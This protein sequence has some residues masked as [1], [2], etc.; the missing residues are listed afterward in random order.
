ME[1]C[2]LLR[3]CLLIGHIY[4]LLWSFHGISKGLSFRYT[5]I[6]IKIIQSEGLHICLWCLWGGN[7]QIS[8]IP[9]LR[10]MI[11]CNKCLCFMLNS[12][13]DSFSHSS[14]ECM[15]RCIVLECAHL[16]CS[17]LK[18]MKLEKQKDARKWAEWSF[19][20][21]SFS[22]SLYSLTCSSPPYSHGHKQPV[23]SGFRFACRWSHHR[24]L[25]VPPLNLSLVFSRSLSLFPSL[26][27]AGRVPRQKEL[28]SP[29][30]QPRV[31]DRPVSWQQ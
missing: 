3:Q 28:S 27:N 6:I 21:I 2:G 17:R 16:G 9:S 5:T 18:M 19:P 23:W 10:S 8:L 20:E 25:I 29:C 24:W 22:L 14:R 15:G 11:L 13:K 12:G 26:E 30:Q 4:C 1:L 31:W 7:T